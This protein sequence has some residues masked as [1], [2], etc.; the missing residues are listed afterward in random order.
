[1]PTATTTPADRGKTSSCA[2]AKAKSVKPTERKSAALHGIFAWANSGDCEQAHEPEGQQKCGGGPEPGAPSQDDDFQQ[3]TSRKRK[4][5]RD[6]DSRDDDFQQHK[7]RK[8]ETP[9]DSDSREPSGAK[10]QDGA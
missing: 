8:R 10:A 2:V 4:I 3:D 6:S 9:H 1:M 7:S 5:S